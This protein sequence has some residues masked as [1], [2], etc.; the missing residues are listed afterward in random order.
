[1]TENEG[2][3][4]THSLPQV[5]FTNHILELS[6]AAFINLGV[7]PNPLT[8]KAE[9]NMQQ[10]RYLIDTLGMLEEKTKGNLTSEE[11]RQLKDI[12]FNLRMTYVK[13]FG[14]RL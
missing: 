11:E 6:T 2:R 3:N 8:G 12:L 9:K 4:E 5:N 7:M 10:A 14:E 13:V 1:M